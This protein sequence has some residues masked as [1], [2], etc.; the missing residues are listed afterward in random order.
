[1]RG[2][3]TRFFTVFPSLAKRAHRQTAVALQAALL[4]L[5]KVPSLDKKSRQS[6]TG[7]QKDVKKGLLVPLR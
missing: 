7:G 1:M 5:E 6:R 3:S 4:V 2:N